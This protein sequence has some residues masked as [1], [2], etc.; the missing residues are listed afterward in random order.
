MRKATRIVCAVAALSLGLVFILPLWRIKLEAP[1]YPEGLGMHIRVNTITGL[2]RNDLQ[3][4]NGLN[5]YVGMARIEPASFPE[6]RYMPWITAGLMVFG[7]ATAATGSRKL[8]V[9]WAVVFA[10]AALAGL[11][12]FYKW[13]Y[14]YGH[15]LNPTAAI[16]VPGLA[17]QPP[18]IGSKKLLNFT[19][20][21]WPATG[22]LVAIGAFF[23]VVA[24]A[25]SELRRGG[26]GGTKDRVDPGDSGSGR[27]RSDGAVVSKGEHAGVRAAAAG[28]AKSEAG[29]PSEPVR[30]AGV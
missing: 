28:P 8:L 12:D 19:A 5:H 1:Q 17:Y 21:S 30:A 22:G 6:L 9:G 26:R 2:K 13:E 16:K 10:V 7:L 15:N 11:F 18:L 20:R 14:D 27:G 29:S 4:I 23:I 3:N 25:G 24:A